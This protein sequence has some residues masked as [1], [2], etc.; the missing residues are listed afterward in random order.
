MFSTMTARIKVIV[1]VVR[2][3]LLLAPLRAFPQ[4]DTLP[5]GLRGKIDE[6]VRQAIHATGA[7]SASIAIVQD[8]RIAYLRAYGE[9]RV[10][11]RTPATPA[12]RYSIGSISKQF[13]ATAVLMLAEQGKLSLDDPVGRFLPDLTRA[14]EVTI[15]QVLSH[16][17]GYQDY[18]PQ[19]YVPPFMLQT[20]S[21]EKILDQW[22]RKP[23][24]F[25]PGT[26]WQY[27]NTG[28][29]IAGLIVERAS[30]QP[31]FE[32]LRR[33]IFIPLGMTT[34]VNV[35]QERLGES[36]ATGYMRYGLGPLR[37]APK[38][39]KGWLFAAGELAMTAEDL[40]RWD[41]SLINQ[42]LLKPESYHQM[43]S[44]MVLKNGIASTYGLGVSV[45]RENSHR[46]ISHGGEV[47]GFTA[48][49]IVFPDDRAAIV[50]LVN[51]D[52]DTATG[53]IA[54]KI[55]P[56]LFP[57]EDASAQEDQ[58]RRI[59]KG[60][61]HG[62]IDRALFS[63]NAN[64]YFSEQALKDIA[65]GLKRLGTPLSLTQTARRERGGMTYR[66]FVA[67]FPGK[68]VQIWQFTLPDG[69]T[70]QFQV[71]AAE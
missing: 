46:S 48:Q 1:H 29:V 34:V 33:H 52:A 7:P 35:D 42:S 2:V 41:I 17:S 70:E 43:E 31:F 32:F 69:K 65:T 30:G 3:L 8:G 49:N 13:A 10:K 45:Q 62:K 28:Y 27:S 58:A 57:Q 25:E 24:D 18:W 11:P 68:T 26:E 60:L 15:R 56:L 16:T 61:Q 54:R 59:F 12:M 66:Q 53:L 20:V 4:T 40:A 39:G 50:V 21:P 37:I 38:E 19:D 71:M 6:A 63:D 9:A 36:D 22:A 5:P 47:S 14:N 44:A 67:K 23:L 51:Q 64:F 55:A